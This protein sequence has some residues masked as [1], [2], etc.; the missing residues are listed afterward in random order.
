MKIIGGILK[1]ITIGFLLI[2][3]LGSGACVVLDISMLH[4]RDAMLFLGLTV[5]ASALAI[6]AGYGIYALVRSFDATPE[7]SGPHS[8]DDR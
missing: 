2:L 8:G 1:I 3:L 7:K 6:G 5:V 4:G